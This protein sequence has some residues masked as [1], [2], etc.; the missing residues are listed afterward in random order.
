M[1]RGVLEPRTCVRAEQ[2]DGTRQ[3][4]EEIVFNNMM[5]QTY[6]NDDLSIFRI[7][8]IRDKIS[9]QFRAEAFNIANQ[10]VFGNPGNTVNSPGSFGVIS[11]TANS[12][13]VIQLGCI[14]SSKINPIS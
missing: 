14:C 8:P 11:S 2:D 4:I 5:G 1:S 3:V 12:P 13:R 9:A 10:V 7:F 6:S